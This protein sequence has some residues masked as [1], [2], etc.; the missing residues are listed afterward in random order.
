METDREN[1]VPRNLCIMKANVRYQRKAIFA[2]KK[3]LPMQFMIK[4]LNIYS[5]VLYFK[6]KLTLSKTTE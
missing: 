2:I 4:T 6:R 1:V 3:D 5:E